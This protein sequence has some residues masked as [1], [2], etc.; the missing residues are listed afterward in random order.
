[1]AQMVAAANKVFSRDRFD[2]SG[3]DAGPLDVDTDS[4]DEES[5]NDEEEEEAVVRVEEKK[6][7]AWREPAKVVKKK[8]VKLAVPLTAAGPSTAI[9]SS[10]PESLEQL[11]TRLSRL[12]IDDVQ[13]ATTIAQISQINAPLATSLIQMKISTTTVDQNRSRTPPPRPGTPPPARADGS[14]RDQLQCWFCGEKGHGVRECTP[15]KELV[16]SGVLA[17]KED[18]TVWADGTP[19]IKLKEE[20][21]LDAVNRKLDLARKTT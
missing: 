13:F 10:P 2:D 17:T 1:M 8:T 15:R 7:L 9:P 19:I 14:Y 6:K 11:V 18:R 4:S 3:D 16:T 21:M 20:T 12:N 5:D